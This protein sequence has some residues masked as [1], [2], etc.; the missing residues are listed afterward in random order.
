MILSLHENNIVPKWFM[1]IADH[2]KGAKELFVEEIFP[3]LGHEIDFH[4]IIKLDQLAES[5]K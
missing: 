4:A 3:R 5:A 1:T 2:D